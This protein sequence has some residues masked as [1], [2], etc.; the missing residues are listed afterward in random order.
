MSDR[1]AALALADAAAGYRVAELIQ[2]PIE[3]LKVLAM[4]YQN[5]CIVYSMSSG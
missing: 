4:G 5:N 1:E 2:T 3:I